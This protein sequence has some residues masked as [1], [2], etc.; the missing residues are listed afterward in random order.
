LNI[1][2][3]P[4]RIDNHPNWFKEKNKKDFSSYFYLLFNV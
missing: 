1:T 2:V 4:A 3:V